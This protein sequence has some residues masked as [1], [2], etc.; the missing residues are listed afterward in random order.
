MKMNRLDQLRMRVPLARIVVWTFLVAIGSGFALGIPY[1]LRCGHEHDDR[2]DHH[3]AKDMA[4][5]TTCP[6]HGNCD[7]P[8]FRDQFNVSSV[9]VNIA[10]YVICSDNGD[11]PDGVGVVQVKTEFL[12]LS[13][14]Y[15]PLGISFSLSE[16]K[17]VNDSNLWTVDNTADDFIETFREMRRKYDR[18]SATR[19]NIFIT[20]A[21]ADTIGFSTFPWDSEARTPSGGVWMWSKYIALPNND[22]STAHEVGHALGLLHTFTGNRGNPDFCSFSGSCYEFVHEPTDFAANYVGDM[23]ADTPAAP[24]TF[25]CEPPGGDDCKDNPYGQTDYRNI[26][27][28]TVCSDAFTLQQGARA[29]CWACTK[30][31]KQAVC[32]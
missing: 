22:S 12:L 29:R 2:H 16:I 30:L 4:A 17:F 25:P 6:V 23:C 14:F 28:Y 32:R 7:D 15:A 31:G 27:S 26:M 20:Q 19:I 5:P 8:E 21:T 10:F 13:R 24:M 11:L 1:G 3:L 18:K 9:T